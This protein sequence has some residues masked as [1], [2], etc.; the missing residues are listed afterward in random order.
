MKNGN[1]AKGAMK[2]VFKTV[3]EIILIL[4]ASAAVGFLLV[5]MDIQIVL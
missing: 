3:L 4:M 5:V 1:Q 2:A